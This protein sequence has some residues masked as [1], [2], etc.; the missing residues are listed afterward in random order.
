MEHYK[1]RI[2]KEF[3]DLL[4]N[5][6]Y[7]YSGNI[8]IA[9]IED[10]TNYDTKQI[11][12]YIRGP[13]D[14]PFENG[15]FKISI[16]IS[17]NYPYTSP[18]IKFITPIYHPNLSNETHFSLFNDLDWS[19]SLTIRSVIITIYSLMVK[20]LTSLI[21]DNSN[22]YSIKN[23]IIDIFLKDNNSWKNRAKEYT[24]KYATHKLWNIVTHGLYINE[25]IMYLLF[26]GKHFEKEKNIP[27]DIWKLYVMPY[28]IG[29]VGHCIITRYNNKYKSVSDRYYY[30]L[31]T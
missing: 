24:D 3:D 15:I 30:N 29:K 8:R 13:I 26:L 21:C 19:P 11:Y 14:S 17:E 2:I 23:P 10:I 31:I 9:S 5:N 4:Y 18:T 20:P 7:L 12:C 25:N 27:S 6:S 22:K 28:I 1:K 16:R